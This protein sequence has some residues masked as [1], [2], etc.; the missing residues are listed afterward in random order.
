[1][2]I[3]ACN[4]IYNR[5]EQNVLH[6]VY[7]LFIAYFRVHVTFITLYLLYIVPASRCI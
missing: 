6:S 7:N 5:G 2:D 4:K 3:P 1:M